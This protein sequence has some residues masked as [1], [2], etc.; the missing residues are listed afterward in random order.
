MD[1]IKLEA[2]V[3]EALG[4]GEWEVGRRVVRREGSFSGGD[5]LT[6]HLT[7]YCLTQKV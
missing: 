7:Y 3:E 2:C 4:M 6:Q 5:R 1:E